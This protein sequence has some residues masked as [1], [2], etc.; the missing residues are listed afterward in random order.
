MR[1]RKGKTD[2][3]AVSKQIGEYVALLLAAT[4]SRVLQRDYGWTEEAAEAFARK[5]A[6]E[7]MVLSDEVI[8]AEIAARFGPEGFGAS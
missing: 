5:V 8:G 1:R 3:E 6:A 4:E 7:A 2:W